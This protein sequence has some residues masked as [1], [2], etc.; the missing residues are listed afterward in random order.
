VIDSRL[1]K[2]K[3]R[4]VNTRQFDIGGWCPQRETIAIEIAALRLTLQQRQFTEIC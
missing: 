1:F 4:D 2:N 3:S